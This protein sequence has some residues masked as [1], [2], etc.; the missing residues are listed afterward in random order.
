[1]LDVFPVQQVAPFKGAEPDCIFPASDKAVESHRHESGAFKGF[2][3][4]GA[5]VA[6]TPGYQDGV[7]VEPR[8][9]G[10]ATMQP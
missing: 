2:A 6:G 3:G 4:M 7:H 5:D 10:T 9:W 1:M 8:S